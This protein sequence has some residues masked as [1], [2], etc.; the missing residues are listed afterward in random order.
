MDISAPPSTVAFGALQD[1]SRYGYLGVPLF[2]LIS[3]FVILM[4]AEGR[5]AGQFAR[6]RF[7]RLYPMFW[8]GVVVTLSVLLVTGKA[9]SLLSLQTILANLTLVPGYFHAPF[10]DGVYWTLAI[11]L[12]FYLLILLAILLRQFHNVEWWL[13]VWLV[14]LLA[15]SFAE[16][17]PLLKSIVLFP[18]GL[19]FLGGA[20]C[21]LIRARGFSITR[22]LILLATV[23]ASIKAAIPDRLS[24]TTEPLI[25][26]SLSVSVIVFAFYFALLL[27]SLKSISL[28]G[29]KLLYWLGLLTYPLYLLH[30]EIGKVVFGA[31]NDL[32]QWPR[33]A[34]TCFLV[35]LAAYACAKYI[36]PQFRSG[37]AAALGSVSR[38]IIGRTAS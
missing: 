18:H 11:E 24:F 30:N 6:S 9:G 29:S 2:F 34:I 4:S 8:V 22:G 5:T 21:Y 3:G 19:F 20:T 35:Y 15:A 10:V 17:M 12:K 14:G 27:V 37:V 36:E 38:L 13:R 26:S 28:S 23:V 31:M 25:A 33:L 1:L 32:P 16:D 7:L